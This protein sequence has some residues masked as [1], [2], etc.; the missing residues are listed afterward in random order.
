MTRSYSFLVNPTSGGGTAPRVVVP[1]ARRLREAGAAVEVTYTSSAADVPPL[2]KAAVAAG[3]VVV[4]VGGDGMLSSVAGEVARAGGVLA[5]L[6]AGR[7]NDFVRQL[8]LP[9]DAD[10]QVRLLETGEPRPIDLLAVTGGAEVLVAGSV[11]CGVDAR[12]GELVNRSHWLP[13]KLQYPVATVRALAT[14]RPFDLA[15]TLEGDDGVQHSQHRA[16]CVVVANS[17]YYGKGV[18]IA[19]SAVV[20]DG[21]LDVVVIEAAGRL[22]LIRSLPKAYDG[23]HV[24]LDEVTVLRGRRVTIS[25][26]YD[27]GSAVP[28]GADGEP[29]GSLGTA[30]DPLTVEL[31]PGAV[32]MLA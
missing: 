27:D 12:A 17:G 13:S 29:L 18:H 23:S 7:G 10:A 21:A 28:A 3:S 31:R 14:Y 16:A 4:A 11:Y 19:P 20:D 8:D 25:G 5:V 24:A 2:V 32:R 15:V 26:T 30:A 1:V 22:D 6:P 9:A